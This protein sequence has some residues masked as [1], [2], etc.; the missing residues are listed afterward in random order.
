[1]KKGIE[2]WTDYDNTGRCVLH[3]KKSRG[4][5]TLDELTEVAKEWEEDFYALIIKAVSEENMQYFDDIET[6]D[7]V[8]LYRA[9]DFLKGNIR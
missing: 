9:T 1:M 8:T 2:C 3:V 5:F 6:G 4:R 7:F